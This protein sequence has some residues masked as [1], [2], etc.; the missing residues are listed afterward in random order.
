M[1]QLIR[2]VSC[3]HLELDCRTYHRCPRQQEVR[4]VYY[5]G[6]F[7]CGFKANSWA[8]EH[9]EILRIRGHELVSVVNKL[10]FAV[11]NGLVI[12]FFQPDE[13]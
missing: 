9:K 1:A 6:S 7:F 3:I 10:R 8:V 12:G 11:F 5:T 2:K 13:E 4:L